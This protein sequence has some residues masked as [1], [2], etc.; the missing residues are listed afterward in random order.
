MGKQAI[1]FNRGFGTGLAGRDGLSGAGWLRVRMNRGTEGE[2]VRSEVGKGGG[3][4]KSAAS[5]QKS[6]WGSH[7]ELL[8]WEN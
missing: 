2:G 8:G 1:D 3:E 5:F 4:E 7:H 6:K